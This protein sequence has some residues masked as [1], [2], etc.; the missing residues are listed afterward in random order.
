MT[1]PPELGSHYDDA[2]YYDHAYSRYKDDVAHY[3]TLAIALGGPVLE[4]GV[5][6]ARIA[7]AVADRGIDLV[8][9]D[10]APNMLEQ[11][12]ARIAKKPKRI[13]ARIELVEGDMRTL[14]LDR[15]FPLVMAPFNAFQHLHRRQ[16]VEAAL[17]TVRAHLAPGGRLAFD[18]LMPDPE[19]LTRSPR[20]WYKCKAIT[21]PKDK[22]RYAYAEAFAYDHD[23]QVQVTSMRFTGHDEQEWVE[24]LPQRQFF[25]RELEALLHYNGFLVERHDGG[26]SEERVDEYAES[27]VLVARVRE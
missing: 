5:G 20:R 3:V 1:K 18:V 27:Q 4:L 9:V 14:R 6:T 15:R 25:P 23:S 11:A 13:G 26:F 2:R 10:L 12:R 16:D 19:S 7:M 24:T 22:R 8:G 17:A 21:H